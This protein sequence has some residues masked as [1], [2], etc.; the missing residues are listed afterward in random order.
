MTFN[1]A[2]NINFD[3]EDALEEEDITNLAKAMEMSFEAWKLGKGDDEQELKD[4]VEAIKRSVEDAR[5]GK[6]KG[7][8]GSNPRIS[9][10]NERTYEL[11]KFLVP[12]S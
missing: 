7:S 4:L 1:L 10:K 5:V 6:G 2:R 12:F 8:I 11:S 9:H 3:E